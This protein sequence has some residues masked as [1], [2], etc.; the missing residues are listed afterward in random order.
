MQAE[1]YDYCLDAYTYLLPAELIA[2]EPAQKRDQSRLMVLSAGED[3][4]EHLLFTDILRF[5]RPGDVLV[6]NN[7]R[8]F[9]A[10]LLGHKESGGKI[11]LFLLT[12]PVVQAGIAEDGWF[13]AHAPALLKSSKRAKPGSFL[14]FG[15][16]LQA[17]VRAL[18][19]GGHAEVLLH[20]RLQPGQDLE[21]LLRTH[22]RMPLPPYI[23][24]SGSEHATE[25]LQRYQTCYACHTGSVAAPTAGLHF[26]PELV[27]A[28]REMGVEIAELTLHV[29]YGT[30]AP[31]RSRDIRSHVIHQE[32][33]QLL[34][35][36][37]ATINAAK[38]SGRR[39]W[40]VG[41]TST[42]SLEFA[43]G[44]KGLVQPFAGPCDLYIYPGFR[45]QVV[46][47]LITNFH[48]PQS[49]LLLLVSALAGRERILAA[50]AEAVQLRYRFFSYGDAMA[51]M[52]RP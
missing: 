38:Q 47:N 37:A 48:L 12:F 31:V 14:S 23:N 49:S 11:E 17:E 2:Q 15:E 9:P 34:P 39:I 41:T 7:T 8:V 36:S 6:L 33:V 30:F 4:R 52:T 16:D 50:Y 21:N 51:I 3:R 35:Q 10:R 29:G 46:D 5:F 1:N 18:H 19:G 43:A 40:A 25:D 27:Q 32:W 13:K 28:L 26:T 44:A 42:R 24:R 45:F 20:Y 22:G